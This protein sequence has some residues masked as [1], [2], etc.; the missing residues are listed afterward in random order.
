MPNRKFKVV[1][2]RGSNDASTNEKCYLKL[3][4]FMCWVNPTE[5]SWRIRFTSN[6]PLV[7][8]RKSFTVK[9]GKA[10]RWFHMKNKINGKKIKKGDIFRYRI[11]K[12][13]KGG[14]PD[15]PAIIS[16]GG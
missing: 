3:R 2:I 5:D 15:G 7:G 10:T 14:G 16:G 9:P 4:D 1:S 12:A 8:G 6:N 13:S 11:A